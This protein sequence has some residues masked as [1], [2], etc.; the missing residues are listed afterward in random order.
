MPTCKYCGTPI[1]WGHTSEGKFIPLNPSNGQRHKCLGKPATSTPALDVSA[2]TG[3]STDA[4][5]ALMGELTTPEQAPAGHE[6]KAAQPTITKAALL[7][8]AKALGIPLKPLVA[9]SL[10]ELRDKLTQVLTDPLGDGTRVH[11]NFWKAL[12]WFTAC[13]TRN[14]WWYGPAGSGKTTLAG[15][16]ALFMGGNRTDAGDIDNFLYISVN[17]Q[18]EAHHFEGFRPVLNEGLYNP[19]WLYNVVQRAHELKAEGRILV[20]LIDECDRGNDGVLVILNMFCEQRKFRFP[21]GEVWSVPENVR[22]IAA[23]NTQGRGADSVYSAAGNLDAAFRDRFPVKLAHE[24]DSEFELLISKNT[25]WTKWV[26]KV[27]NACFDL[28]LAGV[29]ISP[30]VSITGGEALAGGIPWPE[31]EETILWN[32]VPPE[33]H[34]TLREALGLAVD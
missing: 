11:P 28:R 27:R 1:S 30:R 29:V 32:A 14:Q 21:H 9:L 6:E 13:P 15:Q 4:H 3:D 2:Y 22:I 33:F 7:D 19:G 16:L 34:P 18:T 25:D 23:G 20:I 26:Q 24:Y 12:R 10:V 8:K 5:T 31:V 17:G